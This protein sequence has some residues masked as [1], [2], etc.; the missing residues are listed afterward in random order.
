[1]RELM[2]LDRPALERHLDWLGGV[3]TGDLGNSAAG[4]AA[5]AEEAIWEDIRSPLWNTVILATI[6]VVLMI[7]LTAA[8]SGGGD[9]RRRSP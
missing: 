7:P 1:M 3:L 4:Y 5:G 2:G 6:V 9:E 8:R